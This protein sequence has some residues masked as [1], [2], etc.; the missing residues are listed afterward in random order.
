MGANDPKKLRKILLKDLFGISIDKNAVHG[1]D[2]LENAK[3]E[4]NFFFKIKYFLNIFIIAS[5]K[6]RYSS[7]LCFYL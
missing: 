5:G 7:F 2:S 1:S 4:I 3:K 6:A